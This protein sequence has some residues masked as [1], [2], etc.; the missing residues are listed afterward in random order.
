MGLVGRGSADRTGRMR[1][2]AVSTVNHK[3]SAAGAGGGGGRGD[4]LKP[5]TE[6]GSE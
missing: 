5:E 2:A 6:A 1:S 3:T 4:S